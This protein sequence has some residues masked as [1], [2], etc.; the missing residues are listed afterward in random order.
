MPAALSRRRARP[1]RAPRRADGAGYTGVAGLKC[2]GTAGWPLERITWSCAAPTPTSASASG[3]RGERDRTTDRHTTEIEENHPMERMTGKVAV[4]TGAARGQG[5]R[6]RGHARRGGAD[7]SRRRRAGRDRHRAVPDGPADDLERPSARC[8][9]R[10][11]CAGGAR[12]PARHHC[13]GGDGV[14]GR[15]DGVRLDRRAVCNASS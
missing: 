9:R 8:R 2:H 12:R 7:V 10:P 14:S 3:A 1:R 6:A 11:A 5:P 13:R 4:V 15:D